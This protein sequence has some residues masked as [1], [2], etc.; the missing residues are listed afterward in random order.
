[1]GAH[2]YCYFTAYQESI[3]AALGALRETE[4]RAGRYLEAMEAA[5]HL[6]MYKLKFPPDAQSPAPGPV[7]GSIDE[8]VAVF[9]ETGTR[10]IIDIM[11]VADDADICTASPLSK[12]DFILAFET[13]RPT[14]DMVESAFV[15]PDTTARQKVDSILERIG[16]GQA[17][18]VIVYDG[19]KPSQIFFMGYSFD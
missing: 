6:S 17:R 15:R 16:R 10:S 3:A 2:F 19:G 8:L 14:R 13:T 7:H 9:D 11:R 1:M 12:E 5:E 18:Y 4:F